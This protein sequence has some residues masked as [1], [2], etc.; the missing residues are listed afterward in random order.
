MLQQQTPRG[1][2]PPAERWSGEE[3]AMNRKPEPDDLPHR[4]RDEV[5]EID[6]GAAKSRKALDDIPEPGIDPLHEGP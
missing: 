5:E 1:A 4:K 3:V 6:R 2:V